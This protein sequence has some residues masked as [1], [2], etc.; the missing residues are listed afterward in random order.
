MNAKP[1][2]VAP[3][4][5]IIAAAEKYLE[6]GI[7]VVP[8]EPGAK[9]PKIPKWNALRLGVADFPKYFSNGRQLGA[10][11]GL[12]PVFH[13]D[14]DVDDAKV[15]TIVNSKLISG[16]PATG[17]VFGHQSKPRS[18][19]VYAIGREFKSIEYADDVDPAAN[20]KRGEKQKH[21]LIEIR[22]PNL[23]TV[24]PP[25]IHVSGEPIVWDEDL[26]IAK[27]G[28]TTVSKLENWT[29]G[30]AA[31]ALLA[32]HYPAFGDG[33][34][35]ALAF[36][37][38]M[39]VSN[40]NVGSMKEIIV[41]AAVAAGDPDVSERERNVE[42][43]Y[44]R[45]REGSKEVEQRRHLEELLGEPGKK[46]CRLIAKW[47]HI[48]ETWQPSDE[49]IA[50]GGLA[51]SIQLSDAGNA[52]YVEEYSAGKIRCQQKPDTWFVADE[53]D[54]WH[55]DETDEHLKII[56][57]AMREK[58]ATTA[59]VV[60]PKDKERHRHALV[61]CNAMKIAH[62]AQILRARAAIAVRHGVFDHDPWLLGV[63]NGIIDLHTGTLLEKDLMRL[64]AKSAPV[65]FDPDA[66]HPR[67]VK[68]LERVQPDAAMR[69][70][71]QEIAG[72]CLTGIQLERCFIF[73]CG[74]GGNGKS[75]FMA[76]LLALLGEDYGYVCQKA[77]IFQPHKAAGEQAAAANDVADLDGKRLITVEEQRG[78][79]WNTEFIKG[80]TGG[81]SQH[82]R[83]LYKTGRNIK[84]TGKII[85]PANEEP[86]LD[87]F[88]EAIRRRFALLRWDVT[89]TDEEKITFEV[90]LEELKKDLPGILNWALTGL[91]RLIKNKWRL[92]L[93]AAA[94][95]AT[96]KYLSEQDEVKHFLETSFEEDRVEHHCLVSDMYKIFKDDWLEEDRFVMGKKKFTSQLKNHYGKE[97][98]RRG[99]QNKMIV[100]GI[101]L[102]PP[103]GDKPF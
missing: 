81:G 33:H 68:Y 45:V 5:A 39:A 95:E 3:R 71:L 66:D 88:G 67:W 79:R 35:L 61:S 23:Q 31:A 103:L 93:P 2:I 6:L 37:G 83:Q 24:F 40:R 85:V 86:D 62:A 99:G 90:Y 10:L 89:L 78:R 20:E 18:H 53:N 32:R 49:A 46:I 34:R 74:E 43:S 51:A 65:R 25:S 50:E 54:R 98:V 16:H 27:L 102:K 63:E 69:D 38:W 70:C 19:Y 52:D 12:E 92:K 48:Q 94:A 4:S 13:A 91:Q 59:R 57:L 56:E 42:S 36:S 64:V 41:A 28:K 82:A 11:T 15:L 97:R 14:V 29:A 21:M 80:Y 72:A 1:T 22:G 76:V 8:V 47:L 96:E 84:P 9:A 30:V 58:Y 77:L 17:W 87:E 26:A 44:K 101:V 7:H 55:V 60:D 73:F 75:I 100:V